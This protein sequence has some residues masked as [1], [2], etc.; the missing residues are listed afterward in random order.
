MFETLD[1]S[2]PVV[3]QLSAV[4]VVTFLLVVLI[5]SF[6]SRGRVFCQYL[7]IMTGIE[8]SAAQ[9][10]DL[11]RSRGKAGV[12][13]LLIDLIIQEDLADPARLVTPG[14]SPKPSIYDSGVFDE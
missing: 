14:S 7:K 13:D 1:F 11:Y 5:T 2:G 9:V 3:F 6:R 4:A 10:K 8:L 12:R